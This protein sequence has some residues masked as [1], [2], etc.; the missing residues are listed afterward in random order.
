M[1]KAF[2]ILIGGRD[3]IAMNEILY[4]WQLMACKFRRKRN[5]DYLITLLPLITFACYVSYL[6][7]LPE[8]EALA[9]E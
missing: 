1:Y 6:K 3:I 4:H 7:P 8:A 2:V 9:Q 5:L